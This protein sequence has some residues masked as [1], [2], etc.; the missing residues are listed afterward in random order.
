MGLFVFCR[1]I[2]AGSRYRPWKTWLNHSE[3]QHDVRITRGVV[4]TLSVSPS[5][6]PTVSLSRRGYHHTRVCIVG[7]VFLYGRSYG[8][9]LV[10]YS[11]SSSLLSSVASSQ[12][13]LLSSPTFPLCTT[14]PPYLSFLA[15]PLRSL[16]VS[17]RVLRL[18]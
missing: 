15:P 10:L 13:S 2:T 16:E 5:L 6:P 9:C 4:K 7:F 1:P 12:V 14:Q 11:P 17:E 8:G 3:R 18:T